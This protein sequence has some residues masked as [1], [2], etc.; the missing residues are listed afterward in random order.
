[1]LYR[2]TLH[3]DLLRRKPIL[4]NFNIVLQYE[5]IKYTWTD[6]FNRAQLLKEYTWACSLLGCHKE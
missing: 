6:D 5:D 4:E 1:M 2:V 3:A